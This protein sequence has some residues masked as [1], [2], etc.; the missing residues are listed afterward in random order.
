MPLPFEWD[1]NKA[2][3]NLK[4]HGVSFQEA[5]SIFRDLL[6]ASISDTTHSVEESRFLIIGQSDKGRILLVVYIERGEN[7]RI[8]SARHATRREVMIYEEGK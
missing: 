1:E 2:R 4:R 7:I 8:I 6:A 3:A 5:S